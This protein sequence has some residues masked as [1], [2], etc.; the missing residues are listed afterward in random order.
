MNLTGLFRILT[1]HEIEK[2]ES[3]VVDSGKFFRY[4]YKPVAPNCTFFSFSFLVPTR[5]ED[6][7]VSPDETPATPVE[8]PAETPAT[9]DTG[10]S[11]T[12]STPCFA[13]YLLDK[14][15]SEGLE[16]G[17]GEIGPTCAGKG[18]WIPYYHIHCGCC[19]FGFFK[20]CF[21]C[22]VSL[23]KGKPGT[24]GTSFWWLTPTIPCLC[25]ING[26]VEWKRKDAK[27]I[28]FKDIRGGPCG[29]I[30]MMEREFNSG[31]IMTTDGKLLSKYLHFFK[32]SFI[33]S[34]LYVSL[35]SL[36]PHIY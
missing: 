23:D 16:D 10:S 3:G 14:D 26:I 15:A 33:S 12:E 36:F 4:T 32:F 1:M 35:M 29:N 11:S 34:I 25:C 5:M 7:K 2:I 24:S 17:A 8:T 6:A 13:R 27:T 19:S 18:G 30:C 22:A 21:G 31:A 9:Q 20:Y 28:S